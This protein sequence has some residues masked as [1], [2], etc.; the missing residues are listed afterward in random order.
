MF[1][2]RFPYGTAALLLL[3]QGASMLLSPRLVPPPLRV[4]ELFAALLPGEL[5]LHTLASMA[6]TL[7]AVAASSILALPLGILLG[8]SRR[9]DRVLGPLAYLLYPVPKIAFLPV[10]ML[11]LGIGNTA[12]IALVTSVIFFQM[13]VMVRD[14]VRGVPPEYTAAVLAHGGGTFAV[15]RF[16]VLPASLSGVFTALRLAGGTSLAVL[17]FAETFFTTYG[18][19]QFIMDAWSRIDYPR[20][21][22]G[23]VAMSIAGRLIFL[24]VDVLERALCPWKAAGDEKKRGRP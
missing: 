23:I 22:A 10:F 24:G 3:W 15:L 20:M 9:T 1:K 7:S 8:R 11:L 2:P 13:L 6:R 4:L 17:F 12:K 16:V 18:L 21:F 5:G 14:T 19:G